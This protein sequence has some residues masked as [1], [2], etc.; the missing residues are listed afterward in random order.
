MMGD[1]MTPAALR[2]ICDSLNGE[3][4]SGGHSKLARLLDWD[5]STLWRKLNGLS[6]ITRSDE[7]AIRQAVLGFQCQRKP[8]LSTDIKTNQG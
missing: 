2:A 6:K 7:L 4:G 8:P 5:Y 3:R 1:R